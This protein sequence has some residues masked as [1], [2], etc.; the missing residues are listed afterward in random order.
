MDVDVRRLRVLRAVVADGSIRGAATTLGYTP[1]AI[2]Q[3]LTA[4]QRELGLTLIRR[5]G[6]GIEATAAGHVVAAE[7]GRVFQRLADL[8]ALVTDLRAGRSG[9]LSVGY[10]ASAGATWIP[11]IVAALKCE[12]PGLRLDLRLVELIGSDSMPLDVEIAVEGAEVSRQ[13]GYRVRRLLTEPYV[14]VV[15]ASSPLASRPRIDLAELRHEAWVDNDVARGACRQRVLDACSTVGFSPS[16][17]IEAQDYPTAIR[18]V[19]EGI[20]VTV[21]PRLGIGVLPES[22][23]AVPLANPE[24]RRTIV[25]RIHDS[26]A[27]HPAVGR[28]L[29]L[30]AHRLADHARAA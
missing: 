21:V 19:A 3:H 22:V 5:S 6:R 13:E 28:M 18:F 23:V 30:L 4:L 25:V 27:E 15:P 9:S 1:S 10:F 20:G 29:E 8:E 16:F 17:H 2:S 11:P 12:Y 26:C 14:A 24:P 7:A